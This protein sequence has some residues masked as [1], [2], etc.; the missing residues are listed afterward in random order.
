[1]NTE[2]LAIVMVFGMP[3]LIVLVVSLFAYLSHRN[4][5]KLAEVMVE[6]GQEVPKELFAGR[7]RASLPIAKLQ[8][9]LIWIACGLGVGIFFWIIGETEPLGLGAIAFLIG[10][11][12]LIVYFVMKKEAKTLG[13]D[14]EIYEAKEIERM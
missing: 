13:K 11:A 3:V 9:G 1:M 2:D 10:I 6:H 5:M 7:Q 14:G 8:A 12:Y 4:K